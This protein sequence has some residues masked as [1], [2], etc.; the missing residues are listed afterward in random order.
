VD[1]A[2]RTREIDIVTGPSGL[3][4]AALARIKG[5]S[6]ESILDPSVVLEPMAAFAGAL[7]GAEPGAALV[8]WLAA[9]LGDARTETTSGSILVE[10]YLDAPD[11]HSTINL[12]LSAPDYRRASA[13][14][15]P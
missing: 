14:A 2:G 5:T 15:A 4:E 6:G 12:A 13:T 1:P 7:L 10:T 11:T 8:P 3:L 9:H